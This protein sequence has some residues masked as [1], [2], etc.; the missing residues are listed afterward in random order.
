MVRFRKLHLTDHDK[1]S[2]DLPSVV[3]RSN[4]IVESGLADYY[5]VEMVRLI[6]KHA[7]V[8]KKI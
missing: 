7:S 2:D 8:V 4:D 6:D 5:N 3:D 1:F